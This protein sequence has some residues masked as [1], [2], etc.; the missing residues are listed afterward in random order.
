MASESEADK[1]STKPET[2]ADKSATMSESDSNES[3]TESESESVADES[4]TEYESESTESE[5]DESPTESE[6]GELSTEL[7]SKADESSTESDEESSIESQ[8]EAEED[9]STKSSI[10]LL[11]KSDGEPDWKS[12]AEALKDIIYEDDEDCFNSIM[13]S[14]SYKPEVLPD[15]ILSAIIKHSCSLKILCSVLDE[16]TGIR[17][18]VNGICSYTNKPFLYD[19]GDSEKV[20]LLLLHGASTNLRYKGMLP[21]NSALHNLSENFNTVLT[22]LSPEQSVFYMIIKLC[23]E[24]FESWPRSNR[25][26]TVDLLALTTEGIEHEI[27]QYAKEGKVIELAALLLVAREKVMSPSLLENVSNFPCPPECKTLR[28]YITSE[29]ASLTAL[30]TRLMHEIGSDAFL[31]TCNDKLDYNAR[32]REIAWIIQEA[33][34]SINYANFDINEPNRFKRWDNER[35]EVILETVK[36]KSMDIRL[37]DCMKSCDLHPCSNKWQELWHATHKQEGKVLN[38]K[39]VQLNYTLYEYF[40]HLRNRR[41][42]AHSYHTFPCLKSSTGSGFVTRVQA[43]ALGKYSPCKHFASIALAMQRRVR[44]P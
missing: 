30:L 1:S 31:Q 29:I 41:L 5:A 37:P 12:F 24:Y 3:S 10:E 32:F 4:S 7:E 2:E 6:A 16:E 15:E 20:Y 38:V 23:M 11:M 35:K 40:K 43:P 34:F 42:S 9:D 33:G 17:V 27:Y 8:S 36:D 25:L 21:L 18:D 22:D 14:L 44:L 39:K 26:H 19:L 28:Q 13:N